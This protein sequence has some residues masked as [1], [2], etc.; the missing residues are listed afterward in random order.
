MF[1]VR[2][3]GFTID[4]FYENLTQSSIENPGE[5]AV[6]FAK[7]T[8]AL[9]KAAS[10]LLLQNEAVFQHLKKL[11]FD[12][13]I[14]DSIPVTKF[15]YFIPFR[16]GIPFA[17]LRSTIDPW[18]ARIPSLPSFCLIN[19]VPRTDNMSFLQRLQNFYFYLYMYFHY[20]GFAPP[21]P[22]DVFEAYSKY[23][24][25]ES[26]DDIMRQTQLWIMTSD[27]ILS[28]PRP[29]MPHVIEVGSL[30]VRPA[31]PLNEK[32]TA[33][34]ERTPK[35]V[36]VSFGSTSS[37]L[38]K[39][40]SLKFL[41]AFAQLRYTVIWR[42]KNVDDLDIPVNVIIVDWISQ[43]DL[44]AHPNI[45]V[46][47]THCGNNGQFEALY[48]AV[49]MIGMPLFFDQFHNAAR[50][51]HLGFGVV[52]EITKFGVHDLV[53]AVTELVGNKSYRE[54]IRK[55]SL[56]YRDRQETPAERV[57]TAV[58]H[59]MRHGSRMSHAIDMPLYQFF[60]LDIIGF[61]AA[62]VSIVVVGAA[63]FVRM[64]CCGHRPSKVKTN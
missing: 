26:I 39:E 5:V 24:S 21:V 25:F 17:S 28:Y 56:A 1:T 4:E 61:C 12:L 42:F 41:Q 35:F 31:K 14:V 9:P 10:S 43:N 57:A 51:P 3:I 13:A 63:W 8:G 20:I 11:S 22:A 55:A 36:L 29:L 52:L 40:I 30:S 48:H 60:M 2:D 23:G 44:L 64:C 47:I 58:E 45:A 54:N 38:P 46:F 15:F 7:L 37:A 34:A 16:L 18:N 50:L 33:I 62:V 6:I 27:P 49:P 32:W 19:V 53:E 59:L